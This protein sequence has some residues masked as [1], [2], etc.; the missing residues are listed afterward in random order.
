MIVMPL[1]LAGAE[2]VD[3]EQVVLAILP[4]ISPAFEGLLGGEPVTA[5]YLGVLRDKNKSNFGWCIFEHVRNVL[6]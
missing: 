6:Q 5:S 1:P 3:M 4:N 2:L